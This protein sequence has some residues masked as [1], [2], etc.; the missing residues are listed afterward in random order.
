MD[1]YIVVN[2]SLGYRLVKDKWYTYNNNI[3]L[4]RTI[5][6]VMFFFLIY[7]GIEVIGYP[8]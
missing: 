1:D 3:V 4:I 2:S 8:Q 7:Y 6:T 5:K